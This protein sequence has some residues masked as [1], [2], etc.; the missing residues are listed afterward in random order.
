[1]LFFVYLLFLLLL[2]P[3]K[4]THLHTCSQILWTLSQYVTLIH[5]ISVNVSGN[6]GLLIYWT[7]I[8]HDILSVHFVLIM[9]ARCT[10]QNYTNIKF[11]FLFSWD[12]V[13]WLSINSK[14]NNSKNAVVL[15]TSSFFHCVTHKNTLNYKFE[16]RL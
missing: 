7:C 4:C 16:N 8:I 13:L 11:L 6:L 14:R 3:Q 5:S 12:S 1:M 2:N 15:F 9:V 10:S